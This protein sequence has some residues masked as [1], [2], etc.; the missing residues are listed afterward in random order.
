MPLPRFATLD[1]SR[2]AAILRAAAEEFA[3]A[4]IEGASHNRII[5]AAGVSKGA[6]YYY[7]DNKEDLLLTVVADLA[8]RS[9][10]ALGEPGPFADAAGFWAELRGLNARAMAFFLGDPV[11]AGFAKQLVRV[12]PEAPLGRALADYTG[13]LE[14][15][16]ADLLR[17]GQ[18]VGAVR[19]DLPLEL[20]AHLMTGLGESID[21]WLLGRWESLAP[22]T[23]ERLPDQLFDLF[24]RLAAPT[25]A[26][27]RR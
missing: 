24:V 1:P 4:G 5:A 19:D 22:A 16:I 13:R 25:T 21:R 11:V 7:F 9:S 15:W 27:P 26:N 23:A 20:L 17:R 2:R 14:R 3:R 12:S 10:A 18:A 6:M 8:E